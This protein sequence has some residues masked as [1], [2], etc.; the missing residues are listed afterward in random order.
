MIAPQASAAFV[1]AMEKALDIHSQPYDA[2]HPVVCMDE[3]PRQLIRETRE[4]IA[5]RP[6]VLN[7]MTTNTNAAACAMC[8]WP[9]SRWPAGA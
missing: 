9:A 3:T 8:S 7:V 5:Q 1:A 2:K 6:A 4:P